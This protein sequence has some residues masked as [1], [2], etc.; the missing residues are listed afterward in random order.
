VAVCKVEGKQATRRYVTK[1]VAQ[2]NMRMHSPNSFHIYSIE[3][4]F[5]WSMHERKILPTVLN[6]WWIW[7]LTWSGGHKLN[8]SEDKWLTTIQE[9]NSWAGEVT[10][11]SWEAHEVQ[12]LFSFLFLATLRSSCSHK[13]SALWATTF[14]CNWSCFVSGTFRVRFSAIRPLF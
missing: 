9:Q 14:S 1:F 10:W 13:R 11:R 3:A 4:Q 6:W 5:I 8:L 2:Q 7:R 12:G